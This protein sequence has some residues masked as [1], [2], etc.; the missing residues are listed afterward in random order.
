MTTAIDYRIR[1]YKVYEDC[2]IGMWDVDIQT[3]LTFIPR[4]C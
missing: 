1:L 2:L 3:R 4:H